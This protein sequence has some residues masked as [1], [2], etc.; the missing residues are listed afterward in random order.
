MFEL[1]LTLTFYIQYR[2]SDVK[3]NVSAQ[4][5]TVPINDIS[6]ITR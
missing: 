5:V 3:V 4:P 2:V 6:N 1:A